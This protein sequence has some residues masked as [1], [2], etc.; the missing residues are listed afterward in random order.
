M[1]SQLTAKDCFWERLRAREGTTEDEMVGW[2]ID[3]NGRK[4]EQTPGKSEGLGV[5]AF[6]SPRGHK[7]SDMS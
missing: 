4:F 2:H 3:N 6:C 1:K 5:L 7:E